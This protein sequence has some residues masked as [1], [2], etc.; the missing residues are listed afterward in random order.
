LSVGAGAAG[1]RSEII[2]VSLN[3]TVPDPSD[4]SPEAAFCPG[5]AST[6]EVPESTTWLK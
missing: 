1:V 6:A 5:A 2:N 4:D 3:R